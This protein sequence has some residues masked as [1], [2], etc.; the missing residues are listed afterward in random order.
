MHF[1]RYH[2]ETGAAS[3]GSETVSAIHIS[4]TGLASGYVKE[5]SQLRNKTTTVKSVGKRSEQTLYK[6]IH[7]GH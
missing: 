2:Q 4:G 6:K 5:L 7:N 1:Q 3:H